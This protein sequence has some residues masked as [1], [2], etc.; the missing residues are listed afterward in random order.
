VG[1]PQGY[2]TVLSKDFDDGTDL[3]VGQWQRVALARAFFTDAPLVVLDEPS[4]SLDASAEHDLFTSIRSLL[5][6]R[7][8]LLITHRLANVRD[9]DKIYVLE[10]GRIVESGS[11]E[12]LSRQEGVFRELYDLQASWYDSEVPEAR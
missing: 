10:E 4:T 6:G 11:F 9:A 5:H 8:A 1:L 12:Q 3:S 2:E 7:S